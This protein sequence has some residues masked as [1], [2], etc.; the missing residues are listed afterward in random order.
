MILPA[1]WGL[2]GLADFAG[3]VRFRRR[4]GFPARIDA[5]ECVWLTFQGVESTAE[6]RLNGQFL[7]RHEGEGPF[8]FEVTPL[9]AVRNELLVEVDGP[10]GRG[11][12]W[13]EVAL[14]VRCT[15]YLQDVRLRGEVQGDTARLHVAGTVAG[16]ADRPLELYILLDRATVGYATVEAGQPFQ[17]AS[18]ELEPERWRGGNSPHMVRV[19]LVNVA[20]IWYQLEQF[21]SFSDSDGGRT[22]D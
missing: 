14:E 12:L 20:T 15:A 4:F 19:D 11:G 13:G 5:F 16:S 7:G 10:A 18:D 22:G 2:A 3:R 17:V 1:R 6:V 9:L 8:E 21:F